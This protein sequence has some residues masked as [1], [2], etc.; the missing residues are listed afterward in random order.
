[1]ASIKLIVTLRQNLAAKYSK[2]DLTKLDKLI[3]AW[4][5]ADA[6][7]GITS[8]C[9]A[10]DDA[11]DMG[12][13]AAAP[14]A[15]VPTPQKV[16]RKID[17]LWKLLS[18]DYLVLLGAQDVVPMFEVPNPSYDP[19]GDDDT[20]VPTDN[21]Y[22]CSAPF[23]DGD[24]QSYLVPDR[25]VGRIPDMVADSSLDWLRT[26][27]DTAIAHTPQP[28]G[29]YADLYAICCDEW[30]RAGEE[31]AQYLGH[32]KSGLLVTPPVDNA[33]AQAQAALPRTL[34]AIKCHGAKLD[35]NFYGQKGTAYPVALF[36]G[37]LAANLTPGTLAAAMCCYGA[38]VYHPQDPAAQQNGAWPIASTYL[39]KG[40]V[41]FAGA[42][43]IAW[44]GVDTM[45][46]ADWIVAQYLKSASTGASIGRALLEAKQDFLRWL[47][48]QGQSPGLAEQKTLIEFVLLGDP[49]LHPVQSTMV[50][51]AVTAA[52][53]TTRGGAGPRAVPNPSPLERRQRR[54][55][56]ATL[57]SSIRDAMPRRE[58][59]AAPRATRSAAAGP[60]LAD[61]ARAALQD[62]FARFDVQPMPGVVRVTAGAPPAGVLRGPALAAA[63]RQQELTYEYYW[64]G[65]HDEGRFQQIRLL[66]IETDGQGQVL[67]TSVLHSGRAT[68]HPQ[69]RR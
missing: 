26:Y 53:R 30:R 7:R 23:V 20:V 44:V 10:L 55:F 8:H 65:R 59:V 58:V 22:A 36:S 56:R 49:A 31:T 24:I 45:L 13:F 9:V 4:I 61:V 68:T 62:D 43:M 50:P 33:A 1:M 12:K 21:P 32:P 46:C 34:H 19:K 2:A 25:V 54:L 64:T 17:Q 48:Q 42:T 41:G 6:Q 35:P 66:K 5:Q 16:K 57:A 40:A 14:L 60:A 28:A 15:G 51:A 18:P 11:A 38:Q 47:A 69:N 52:L 3:K 67:R 63:A 39:R 37:T 27:L 29:H